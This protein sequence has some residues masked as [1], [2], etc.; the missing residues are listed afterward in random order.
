MA[1]GER[2]RDLLAELEQLDRPGLVKAATRRE[3]CERRASEV[4]DACDRGSE[5]SQ[6]ELARRLG[7]DERTVRDW[8]RGS[9][10][11]PL[12]AVIALPERER[13]PVLR[14]LF[15]AHAADRKAG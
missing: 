11:V 15:A 6:R 14:A 13:E 2:A 9:R 12:W 3:E 4:F 7:V 10:C 5:I 1:T 8:R